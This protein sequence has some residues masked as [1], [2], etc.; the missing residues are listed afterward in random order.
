MRKVIQ[1]ARQNQLIV[2]NPAL[3][4]QYTESYIVMLKHSILH[5]FD[6]VRELKRLINKIAQKEVY[7]NKEEIGD[8]EEK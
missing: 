1:E 8:E 7:D 2:N 6:K 3:S 5:D 4:I